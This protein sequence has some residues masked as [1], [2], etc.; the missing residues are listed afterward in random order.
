MCCHISDCD[1]ASRCS[2]FSSGFLSLP[3]STHTSCSSSLGCSFV[4]FPGPGSGSCPGTGDTVIV[5]VTHSLTYSLPSSLPHSLFLFSLPLFALPAPPFCPPTQISSISPQPSSFHLPHPPTHPPTHPFT[6]PPAPPA[7]PPS[8][9]PLTI[10]SSTHLSIYPPIS[11]KLFDMNISQKET[12]LYTAL[13]LHES[14]ELPGSVGQAQCSRVRAVPAL[15][16]PVAIS[17]T[18]LL[19]T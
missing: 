1:D 14:L 6:C 3:S 10:H 16:G 8:V 5:T 13:G 12:Q 17:P 18:L 7:P 19:S 15:S 11:L 9:S 4:P 2:I